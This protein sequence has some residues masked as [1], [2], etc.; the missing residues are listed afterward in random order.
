MDKPDNTMVFSE[1]RD[2]W[3]SLQ[4]DILSMNQEMSKEDYHAFIERSF[5][6]S[7]FFRGCYTLETIGFKRILDL[8]DSGYLILL[9]FHETDKPCNDNLI[10]DEFALHHFIKKILSGKNNALGPLIT[11]RISILITQEFN[12]TDLTQKEESI[13]LCRE[14]LQGLEKHFKLK[15]KACIG[16]TYN[17]HSIY[18]SFIDALT[19]LYYN[20]SEQIV[21]FPDLK[22]LDSNVQ[23]DFLLAESHL[24]EAVRLRKVE[25]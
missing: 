11:N 20:R 10:T 5:M 1:Q 9:E 19:C 12:G 3:D 4:M 6:F 23:F 21:Y 16:G 7:M 17:I 24:L 18:S 14:L 2:F 15:V 25:A 22:R 8:K 13:T